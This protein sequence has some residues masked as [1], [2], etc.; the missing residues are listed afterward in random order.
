[1][2][3]PLLFS[4][5][6]SKSR[7]IMSPRNWLD[8]PWLKIFLASFLG[9]TNRY[10]S[11]LTW[12][13]SYQFHFIEDYSISSKN[14]SFQTSR[15]HVSVQNILHK[16]CK[17]CHLELGKI[18]SG[19]KK[20]HVTFRMTTSKKKDICLVIWNREQGLQL[21]WYDLSVLTKWKL[22]L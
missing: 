7:I 20:T 8:M 2:K 1:M 6:G 13:T 21:Y 4:K 17:F 19:I 12:S 9:G 18:V 10:A 15:S 3:G 14:W 16:K 5:A 22:V 11:I